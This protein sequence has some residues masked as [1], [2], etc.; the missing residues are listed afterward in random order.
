MNAI[1]DKAARL[2]GGAISEG[3]GCPVVKPHENWMY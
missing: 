1:K 2:Y 3:G